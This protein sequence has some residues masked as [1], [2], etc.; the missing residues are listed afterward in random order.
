M[1]DKEA[2]RVYVIEQLIKGKITVKQAA[3]LLGL[4]ERQIKRLKKGVL[5]KGVGFLAHGNR[6]RKPKHAIDPWLPPV[7]R[8]KL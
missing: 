1:S 4:S 6:G 8:C 7:A 2:R 3:V 5:E